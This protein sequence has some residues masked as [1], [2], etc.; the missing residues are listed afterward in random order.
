MPSWGRRLGPAA[1]SVSVGGAAVRAGGVQAALAVQQGGAV[2]A[3]AVA[4]AAYGASASLD[5]AAG[6]LS[7]APPSPHR[8]AFEA[9]AQA[10]GES[11]SKRVCRRVV[12]CVRPAR[13]R[14]S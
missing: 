7:S 6:E 5:K 4:D 2:Q 1:A 13:K 3:E 12:P 11:L 9:N 10:A 14:R 8:D